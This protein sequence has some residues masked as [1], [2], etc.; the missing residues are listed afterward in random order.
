MVQP[1]NHREKSSQESSDKDKLWKKGLWFC[2]MLGRKKQILI[3]TNPKIQ[4]HKTHCLMLS[5][6]YLEFLWPLTCNTS[7][8]IQYPLFWMVFSS[9][10]WQSPCIP[11]TSSISC[12]PI[13]YR[14]LW[15]IPHTHFVNLSLH[16]LYPK[17]HV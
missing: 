16:S 17:I 7:F 5:I 6:L 10:N 11:P 13:G 9:F 1:Q 12:H 8:L 4:T 15:I 2:N 14:V 3:G